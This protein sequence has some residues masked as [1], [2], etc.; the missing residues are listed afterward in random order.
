M[1]AN[2]YTRCIAISV[3]SHP[4]EAPDYQPTHYSEDQPFELSSTSFSKQVPTLRRLKLSDYEFQWDH[5]LFALP[6][7]MTL[8][9]VSAKIP[10]TPSQLFSLLQ[11]MLKLKGPCLGYFP[12]VSEVDTQLL[13]NTLPSSLEWIYFEGHPKI[14]TLIPIRS[15]NAL[16]RWIFRRLW[17]DSSGQPIRYITELELENSY[18]DDFAQFNASCKPTS[19]SLCLRF[20]SG[21]NTVEGNSGPYYCKILSLNF[22]EFQWDHFLLHI[23]SLTSLALNVPLVHPTPNQLVACLRSLPALTELSLGVCDVRAEEQE[24]TYSAWVAASDPAFLPLL[25]RLKLVDTIQNCASFFMWFPIRPNIDF[26]LQ[27]LCD[28]ASTN[29]KQ[30]QPFLQ[31]LW[32][33]DSQQPLQYVTEMKLKSCFVGRWVTVEAI[34]DKSTLLFLQL[35]AESLSQGGYDAPDKWHNRVAYMALSTLPMERLQKVTMK[36]AVSDLDAQGG[37][38]VWRNQLQF[39]TQLNEI[40]IE[41]FSPQFGMFLSTWDTQYLPAQGETSSEST[42]PPKS[43]LPLFSPSPSLKHL[44]FRDFIF[45]EDDLD[46]LEAYLKKRRGA[47]FQVER[48]HLA[49]IG[50]LDDED[51]N[52]YRHRLLKTKVV[53]VVDIDYRDGDYDLGEILFGGPDCDDVD[54]N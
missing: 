5:F 9:I 35:E 2:N 21:S 27:C 36:L 52:Q 11:R 51:L 24:H 40:N 26:R 16:L 47:G 17:G 50:G 23:S 28:P 32:R 38:N 14:C 42:M 54:T 6:M 25:K 49:G 48:L 41:S 12:A 37:L 20:E 33:D 44:R 45:D 15:S 30:L 46:S 7:I 34:S 4:L 18:S 39:F 29:D 43:T 13:A 19:H 31:H 3:L 8:E 10:P 22:C 53:G 1:P